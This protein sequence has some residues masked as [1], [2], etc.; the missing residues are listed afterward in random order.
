[1]KS[2]H[3]MKF[4]ICSKQSLVII[5]KK[6]HKVG[7]TL[8]KFCSEIADETIGHTSLVIV[9]LGF[10]GFISS[11]FSIF[12]ILMMLLMVAGFA[13]MITIGCR[14]IKQKGVICFLP[15]KIQEILLDKTLFQIITSPSDPA[16][17]NAYD[18]LQSLF[19]LSLPLQAEELFRLVS[20]L[21]EPIREKIF[22]RGLVHLLP[23]SCQSLLLPSSHPLPPLLSYNWGTPDTSQEANNQSEH[24]P[25]EQSEEAGQ[26]PFASVPELDWTPILA[27]SDESERSPGSRRDGASSEEGP[28]ERIPSGNSSTLDYYISGRQPSRML[29][30]APESP[31]Q[32]SDLQHSRARFEQSRALD[33]SDDYQ[34]AL[35][36][37]VYG[38]VKDRMKSSIRGIL[39][40]IDEDQTRK[41]AGISLAFAAASI[42]YNRRKAFPAMKSALNHT[43]FGATTLV[44]TAVFFSSCSIIILKKSFCGGNMTFWSWTKYCFSILGQVSENKD[45]KG[46]SRI[47]KVLGFVSIMIAIKLYQYRK[48]ERVKNIW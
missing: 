2:K 11:I 39:E 29:L 27:C 38:I 24:R 26:A 17:V 44:P 3:R 30:V 40:C 12:T 19:I 15:A 10:L 14:K 13:G 23:A 36:N 41:V 22:Q 32:E 18:C 1:M 33:S 34:A 25:E 8:A 4:S 42:F 9:G 5:V 21:P 35:F 16:G 45:T 6:M 46:S 20:A 47:K 43:M 48:T 37:E 31:N 28:V 7:D